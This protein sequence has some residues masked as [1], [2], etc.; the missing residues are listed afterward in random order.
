MNDS[1]PGPSSMLSSGKKTF[2][3]TGRETFTSLWS[4]FRVQTNSDCS[5]SNNASSSSL[6][7]SSSWNTIKISIQASK[8]KKKETPYRMRKW[9]KMSWQWWCTEQ[10]LCL[11]HLGCTLNFKT[12]WS[13]FGNTLAN[14]QLPGYDQQRI[15]V[16]SLIFLFA[17]WGCVYILLEN[18]QMQFSREHIFYLIS[19]GL[20]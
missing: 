9:G 10:K 18:S 12:K 13:D 19:Y 20:G 8:K 1:W 7:F 16:Y 15:V 3:Y 5:A 17:G 6:R 11:Y 2:I 14:R 4:A